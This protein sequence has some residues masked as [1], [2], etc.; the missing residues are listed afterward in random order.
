[1]LPIDHPLAGQPTVPIAKLR[2]EPWAIGKEDTAYAELAIRACRTFGGFEPDVR[3]RSNDLLML[4]ALVS[5]G[6]AV[7]LLPDLVRADREPSVRDARRRRGAADATRSSER[8]ATAAR[9]GRRSMHCEPPC[10]TRRLAFGRQPRP[11]PEA[12]R[13]RGGRE[14]PPSAAAR[15]ATSSSGAPQPSCSTST[16]SA[17]GMY[18]IATVADAG[19]SAVAS[20]SRTTR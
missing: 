12:T 13:R 1:M 10:V 9:G 14:P 4:L 8:S 6:Q 15:S 7:T 16:A 5:N 20:A 17:P 18:S 3:H 11:H 2:D 19:A